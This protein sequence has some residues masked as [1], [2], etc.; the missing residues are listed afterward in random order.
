MRRIVRRYIQNIVSFFS[1]RNEKIR[2]SGQLLSKMNFVTV[3]PQFLELQPLSSSSR[4]AGVDGKFLILC[5]EL[6]FFL[7][8]QL[9]IVFVAF[10]ANN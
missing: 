7:L 1:L 2:S 3:Q 10:M 4:S 5:F 9:L 6:A 8:N